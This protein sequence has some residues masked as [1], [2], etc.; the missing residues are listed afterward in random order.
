MLTHYDNLPISSSFLPKRW[1]IS[2]LGLF[3]F[4][5]GADAI[6]DNTA[7]TVLERRLTLAALRENLIQRDVAALPVWALVHAR[8]VHTGR[9]S[10]EFA[11]QL[12]DAFIADTFHTRYETIDALQKYCTH[13]TA[14]LGRGFLAIAGEESASTEASDAL[15]IALQLLNHWRDIGHDARTLGRIYLPQTWL[16]EYNADEKDLTQNAL[17]TP[18]WRAVLARLS[19]VIR[20]KLTLAE[21]LPPSVRS[22][23]LRF[24]LRIMLSLAHQ[25]HESLKRGD[26]LAARIS[27]TRAM[28]KRA[29]RTSIWQSLGL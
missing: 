27:P 17:L 19:D 20:E 21:Q 1:R 12:L 23:R 2:M 11:M 5:R 15:C 28:F 6:A 3:D 4:A 25:W 14:S 13:S 18:A 26:V 16:R 24:Q 9:I 22:T 29:V 10:S 7:L 8:D